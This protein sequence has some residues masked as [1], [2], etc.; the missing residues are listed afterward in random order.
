M[1]GHFVT[2]SL[3]FG[4]F[5]STCFPKHSWLTPVVEVEACRFLFGQRGWCPR[6]YKE[7]DARTF[8]AQLC[9]RNTLTY[10]TEVELD[11]NKRSIGIKGSHHGANA[12]GGVHVTPLVLGH[13]GLQ[14][15]E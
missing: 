1:C 2:S 7:A 8:A 14:F 4:V 11:P 15:H 6:W 12:R 3:V 9:S 5:G 10:R 13:G